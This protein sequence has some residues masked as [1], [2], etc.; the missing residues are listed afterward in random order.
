MNLTFEQFF[1]MATGHNPYKWH[2]KVNKCL[3]DNEW[4]E[5]LAC[6]T[7]YG[8]TNLIV[9]WL[10]CIYTQINQGKDRNVPI[11]LHFV[12]DRRA[13]VDDN[14]RFMRDIQRRLK[15]FLLE[16]NLPVFNIFK[17]RGGLSPYER[18]SCGD[19]NIPT[20]TMST[21]DQYGSR[22]LYKSYGSSV[23]VRSWHAGLAYFDS[24]LIVDE[25][26]LN[27]LRPLIQ[28]IR[29]IQGNKLDVMPLKVI[30]MTATHKTND[31]C[32][33]LTEEDFSDLSHRNKK[34][35]LIV[36]EK[37]KFKF[38][39][40]LVASLLKK[41][42]REVREKQVRSIPTC[43][44]VV[45]NTVSTARERYNEIKND[46]KNDIKGCLVYLIHGQNRPHILTSRK[47]KK[48]YSLL[49]HPGKRT[50]PI[51][52]VCTQTLEVAMDF[53]F[54]HMITDYCPIDCLGQRA[55]RVNRAGEIKDLKSEVHLVEA[56]K[57]TKQEYLVY[58]ELIIKA[59]E[60]LKDKKQ[61]PLD[62]SEEDKKN[63]FTEDIEYPYLTKDDVERL[64]ETNPENNI[65]IDNYLHGIR[66]VDYY[67]FVVF[68][69]WLELSSLNRKCV[70]EVE[71]VG[72]KSAEL[73]KVPIKDLKETGDDV[74]E[75]G[76]HHCVI[77]RYNKYFAAQLS[78]VQPDDIVLVS[79]KL[80]CFHPINGWDKQ[81]EKYLPTDVY[82]EC[83]GLIYERGNFQNSSDSE[84]I[85][86][87]STKH[88]KALRK[89]AIKMVLDK[90]GFKS[91]F[92]ALKK[93]GDLKWQKL[94]NEAL[95]KVVL[96]IKERTNDGVLLYSKR[97]DVYTNKVCNEFI[98]NKY[99]TLEAHTNRVKDFAIKNVEFLNLN[100]K[101]LFEDAALYHDLGK[102]DYRFQ[103]VMYA[104][105]P[106]NDNE[107]LGKSLGPTNSR[108]LG[109]NQRHE[110]LSLQILKD[111]GI[112]EKYSDRKDLL[113][114]LIGTHHGF[115]R[116]YAP[117]RKD[118]KFCPEP[119]F[120]F[121]NRVYNMKKQFDGFLNPHFHN[122][123]EEFG[124]W[125]LSLLETCF[126]L[127]DHHASDENK[128]DN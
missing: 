121:M 104:G 45:C 96:L 79:N 54:D 26:H 92:A 38:N 63:L 31:S 90:E 42:V 100:F 85:K 118:D 126:R 112:L 8:K 22:L 108:V 40:K 78:D 101:K 110:F 68:R 66:D 52:C 55:G 60:F 3:L 28:Q 75:I 115:Y 24:L 124:P 53:D 107:Y 91:T 93:L 21:V 58:G 36:A 117:I 83:G 44:A 109:L 39:T 98:K 1:K 18:K 9:I 82:N 77:K 15:P 16:N 37:D 13:V 70:K 5:Q 72:V 27:S 89:T 84:I 73:I 12:I 43:I 47:S 64:I 32:F 25:A 19:I 128:H 105:K 111:S 50:K 102:V 62:I 49:K 17:L 7:G 113:E 81:E 2:V 29:D 34:K 94:L 35:A 48:M 6:N 116:P 56:P 88:K 103:D 74:K 11:R 127:A 14:F 41:Q 80:R 71:L 10:Y 86:N 30:E 69:D 61:L 46:I 99:R 122:L 119:E 59:K 95:K 23:K 51:V 20:I 76:W 125:G 65:S 106:R 123:N 4:Y 57:N 87:V 33:P 67:A 114:H 97:D 120:T